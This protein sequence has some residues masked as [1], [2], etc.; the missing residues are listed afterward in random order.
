MPRLSIAPTRSNLLKTKESL[1]LARDGHDLLEQKREVLFIEL[2]Q[3]VHR[4]RQLEEEM[5]EK[6]NIAFSALESAILSMGN[7]SV[8]WASKAVLG[9]RTMSI[10]HRSVMGVPI[11]DLQEIKDSYIGLQTSLVGTNSALDDT[12]KKFEAL[13]EVLYEWSKVE[14]SVWRLANEIKKTQRRVNALENIFIPDYRNTI[15]AIEDVL[16]E[17][18]REEFIRKKKV[19]SFINK[20]RIAEKS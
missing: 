9:E 8:N 3:I 7:E 14:I 20:K 6:S 1:R 17:S 13:M 11:I 15:K 5:A 12:R 2:M 19:K 16:E 4:L 10:T 18:D